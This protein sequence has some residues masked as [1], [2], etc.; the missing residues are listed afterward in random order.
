MKKIFLSLIMIM[1]FL[2][3]GCGNLDKEKLKS[4]FID[5]VKDLESYYMTGELSVN[6]NDDT[7][8]YDVS[9][10]YGEPDNF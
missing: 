4:K 7:Y 10:S 1:I 5:D 3:T 8:N 6:N 9:V 2:L